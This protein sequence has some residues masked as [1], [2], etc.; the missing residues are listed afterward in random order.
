MNY[1]INGSTVEWRLVF[2]E[3]HF[4]NCSIFLVIR[5][6]QIKITQRYHLTPVRMA[7]IKNTNDSLCWRGCGVRGTLFHCWWEWKPV[8]LT[9]KSIGNQSTSRSSNTTLGNI[10]KRCPIILQKH[11]FNYV[12]STIICNNQYME[13]KRCSSM[14]GWIKKLWHIYTL[15]YCS[16]GKKNNNTLYF[17]FK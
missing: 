15:G 3:I 17:A 4:K 7:K 2:D 12:H 5:E 13:Q 6:M 1:S 10:P 8:Q 9:W 14:D 11:L 16:V